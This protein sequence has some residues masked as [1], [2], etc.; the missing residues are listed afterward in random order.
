LELRESRMHTA[1]AMTSGGRSERTSISCTRGTDGA[2]RDAAG[3]TRFTKWI[4]GPVG[5]IIC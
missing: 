1:R 2:T 5:R 3:G 4:A